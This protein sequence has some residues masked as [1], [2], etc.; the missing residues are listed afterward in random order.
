MKIKIKLSIIVIAIVVAVAG[1]IAVILLNQ[2]SEI[3]LQKSLTV[4]ATSMTRRPNTG[5][6]GKTGIMR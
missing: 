1:G 6:A 5:R 4:S 2:A 3:I